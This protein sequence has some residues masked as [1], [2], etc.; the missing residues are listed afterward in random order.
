MMALNKRE[1]QQM[2]FHTHRSAALALLND[3]PALSRKEAGFLG[4]V[5]VTTALTEKQS[6]W[7][8]KLLGKHHLPPLQK[9]Q[10][11]E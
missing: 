3:C 4:N 6:S 9:V 7:L 5:A 2:P 8:V 1:G 10:G 11:H